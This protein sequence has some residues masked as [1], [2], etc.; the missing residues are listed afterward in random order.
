MPFCVESALS[1]VMKPLTDK[2]WLWYHRGFTAPKLADGKRLLLHFGAVDWEAVV[3]VNGKES[4]RIA[5]GM[6][7]S[8]S[9][10]PTR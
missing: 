6:I 9:T 10:S 3:S 1:G 8:R 4:A 2:Q 5:A 7:R